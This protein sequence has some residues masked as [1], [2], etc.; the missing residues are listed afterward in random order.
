MNFKRSLPYLALL[1]GIAALRG[2]EKILADVK[3]IL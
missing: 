1:T 3:E 2:C